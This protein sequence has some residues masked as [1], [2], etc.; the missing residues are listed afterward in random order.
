MLSRAITNLTG[1]A[2]ANE[3]WLSLVA[4]QDTVGIK[5]F[6]EPGPNSGTRPAVTE[7]VVKAL[8]AAGLS[9]NKI[10]IWDKHFSSL[11]LAGYFDLGKRLG[12]RIAGSA[13][14]GYDEQAFYESSLIGNLVWG[15]FEFGRKGD[16][17][18]RKSYVSKL[19]TQHITKIINI[20]PMM[21]QNEVG[22]A[23]IL[24]S[25]ALG[26]VDNTKRFENDPNRL[27]TAVP[28]IYALPA[29]SD[30]VA[31]NIVDGLICQYE[32]E[33]RSL[34]HYSTP[35][36]QLRLSR[37]PVALDAL[38]LQELERQRKLAKAP[39]AK[40]NTELYSNAELLE[41][42]VSDLKKIQTIEVR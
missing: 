29:F 38:S 22:V 14:E 33:E 4:T 30:R 6:S 25:L 31:L 28:E 32:G 2:T 35:L 13:E 36:N 16:G 3:A 20:T 12:V 34:L 11:R 15:D 42:G 27:A 5:V 10:V 1:K 19:V 40:A 7:A 24:Y 9:T 23:G 18:G 26:S 17:I 21:N 39:S 41:L 37:D 8:V